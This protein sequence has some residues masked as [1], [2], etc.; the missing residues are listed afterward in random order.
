MR[1]WT[2]NAHVADQKGADGAVSEL[3]LLELKS[4][5]LAVVLAVMKV[6]R[7]VSELHL[8]AP[9]PTHL[10]TPTLRKTPRNISPSLCSSI[11]SQFHTFLPL[12]VPSPPSP[13]SSDAFIAL[14]DVTKRY[15]MG[16]TT[17]QALRGVTLQVDEGAFVAVVGPSGSGKSTLLALL[18]GLDRPSSGRLRVGDWDLQAIDR[19]TQEQYRRQMV[20]IVFQQFHLI[21][22]MTARENVA[23]PLVLAGTPQA[24]RR[25]RA[26]DC[27][28]EVGLAD[29]MNHR[30]AELSGGEQQ[31]VALARALV[32]NPP[33]LLADEPTGNLDSD[34]GAQIIDR[35]AALHRD[36]R[37]VVVVT[38]HPAEVEHVAQRVIRLHDGAR[39]E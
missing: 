24:E 20:G 7:E 11:C 14:H 10:H 17:V 16:A 2:L 28:T 15:R 9:T 25:A 37:T 26:A 38:H 33:L 6:W 3:H 30:P 36:G 13:D 22:T 39:V 27:L 29:R 1:T 23:L 34:T 19:A 12:S 18:A 4:G 31:R 32:G 35:L 8:D 5:R 21:P